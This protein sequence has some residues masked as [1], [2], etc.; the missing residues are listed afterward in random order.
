MRYYALCLTAFLVLVSCQRN[1]GTSRPVKI[2]L[3]EIE[4]R[5]ELK[6][7]TIYSATS[8]FIY[9]GRPM[10]YE[11]ELLQRMA[12]QLGLKLEMVIAQDID[13][14]IDML[15]SGKGD[16]AAASLTITKARSERVAFTDYLITTRQV[17]VQRKPPDWR[18]MKLHEIDEALIRSPI[19]LIGKEVHVR[20][21]SSYHARLKN[22]SEEIG[23]DIIIV[24]V[25]GNVS[26]E[27]IISR[28]A[29]G[30]I[31]YTIADEN[32]ALINQAYYPILDVQTPVS[33]PQRIAWALRK[34]SPQLLEAVNQW[35]A[36]MKDEVD[37]YVIYNKYFKNRRAFRERLQSEFFSISGSKISP[38][39]D[40]IKQFSDTL[41][42]DWRLLASQVYQESRFDPRSSSWAG[43]TGLM[44]MLP[45]TAREFGAGDIYDPFENLKAA[46]NYLLWLQDYYKDIADDDQRLKFV[47][48]S[49]NC[50]VGHVE[51]ARQLARKHG[52]KP[53]QWDGHV[54]KCVLLLSE[55][56]YFNDPVVQYG[57]CRGEEPY[58]YV[59]EILDRYEH[60]KR[61]IN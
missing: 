58:N 23:G 31:D 24:E 37:Y 15:N 54:A 16:I 17:L 29:E 6:A 46:T 22:L 19:D 60:Y 48:A 9:K 1:G 28:V 14:I 43:A 32:I 40:Y 33:F 55:E 27:K 5:G 34:T 4:Q 57:Y 12:D 47:L 25:P 56:E 8:Y 45:A 2:D 61:L 7:I 30:E 38:Y 13:K 59:D 11:Y 52:S 42:W 3:P 36:S 50:G 49:Y 18:Q 21:A 26:T 53:D 39:D 51:D 20:K 44:Q 35:I 41:G 10:G